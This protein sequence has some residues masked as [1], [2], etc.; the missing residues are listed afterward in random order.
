MNPEKEIQANGFNC[1]MCGNKSTSA[2]GTIKDYQFRLCSDCK[3]VF[4]PQ[5]AEV[6]LSQLYKN[7][8]HGPADGA[9]LCGWS[10]NLSFL[11]P[12]FDL[13]APKH[14]LK[15][16]DFGTGQDTVPDQLRND[17]HRVLA[18]DIASP[19][20]PHPDRL[21]G[22]LLQLK[23]EPNQF[24]LT[25]SFQVF[26]HLPQPLPLLDEL[27]R[28]TKPGGLVLIHT[29]M[30][31]PERDRK[32]FENWWYAAPPDHCCFYR[33]ETFQVYLSNKPHQLIWKDPKQVLIKKEFKF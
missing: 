25:Y 27:I 5:I 17:G 7:G 22:D 13:L 23:L 16:L 9:P 2:G 11:K 14:K 21:T 33:H 4:C 6:Y 18:V 20:R 29:D 3:F 26:E 28:L 19:L 15:I 1:P 24:D 12:A 30:E 10:G 8:F 32:G 31:T